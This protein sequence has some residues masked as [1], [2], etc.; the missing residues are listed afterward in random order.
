MK[1]GPAPLAID[2]PI[3]LTLTSSS[4]GLTIYKDWNSWGY[5]ARFFMASVYEDASTD[6]IIQ[7]R[8]SSWMKNFQDTLVLNR[9]EELDTKLDLCDGSWFIAPQLRGGPNVPLYLTPHFRIE[10]SEQTA[11]IWTGHIT[12]APIDIYFSQNC[13]DRLNADR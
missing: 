8:L 1:I 6:Y 10:E 7:R 5:Y 9:G 4:D 12:G 2:S 13:R 3:I 11:Q